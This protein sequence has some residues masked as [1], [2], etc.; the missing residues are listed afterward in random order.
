M[1]SLFMRGSSLHVHRHSGVCDSG[2][3]QPCGLGRDSRV[4]TFRA[5]KHSTPATA[6]QKIVAFNR[7]R[8][9][10]AARRARYYK[11][12]PSWT[13]RRVDQDLGSQ[14]LATEFLPGLR[15]IFP[16]FDE[17]PLPPGGRSSTWP[18]TWASQAEEVHASREVGERAA[19]G[20]RRQRVS[21]LNLPGIAVTNGRSN[22]S[23][24]RWGAP[25]ASP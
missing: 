16:R 12:S 9:K 22:S 2:R 13:F 1:T 14:P 8:G 6:A 4:T 21:S 3:R 10:P 24:R 15:G 19:L 23:S 25:G 17:F 20:R 11:H 18:T 5:A 7:I